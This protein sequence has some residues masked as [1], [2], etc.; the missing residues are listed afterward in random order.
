MGERADGPFGVVARRRGRVAEGSEPAVPARCRSDHAG[1]ARRLCCSTSSPMD[2]PRVRITTI[3]PMVSKFSSTEP[4]VST[5]PQYDQHSPPWAAAS[6]RVGRGPCRSSTAASSSAISWLLSCSAR[7]RLTTRSRRSTCHRRRGHRPPRPP[8]SHP[9]R[10]SARGRR[11]DSKYRVEEHAVRCSHAERVEGRR[12]PPGR[13][14]GQLLP[15]RRL[16]RRRS[17]PGG[18]KDLAIRS[19]GVPG[20]GSEMPNDR[21][22]RLRRPVHVACRYGSAPAGLRWITLSAPLGVTHGNPPK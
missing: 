7:A 11:S 19:N 1:T 2:T 13:A 6:N 9:V 17:A 22:S 15:W 18:A 21:W 16:D 12:E 4:T 5:S 3:R 14:Q 20:S 10:R 8:D